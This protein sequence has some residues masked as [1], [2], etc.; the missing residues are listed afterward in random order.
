LL[1]VGDFIV[2]EIKIIEGQY[3]AASEQ[4]QGHLQTAS[5]T[6]LRLR[7]LVPVGV[8]FITNSGRISP[9]IQALK[10]ANQFIFPFAQQLWFSFYL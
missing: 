9:R 3:V 10:V 7:F 4:V 8:H 1:D 2:K 5:M 6:V